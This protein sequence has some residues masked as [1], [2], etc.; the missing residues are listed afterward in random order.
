MSREYKISSIRQAD[1]AIN[2]L[3]DHVNS[4]LRN[5]YN[6]IDD[7]R[8]EADRT[9]QRRAREEAERAKQR[10]ESILTV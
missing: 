3:N 2:D 4:S 8:R 7:V 10:K 9:A 6:R 5:M 1:D